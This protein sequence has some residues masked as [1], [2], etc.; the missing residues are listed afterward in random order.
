MKLGNLRRRP[1]SS[2]AEHGYF[3]IVIMIMVALLAI[4]SLSRVQNLTTELKR[5]REE[6]LVHRGAQ[7]AR[8]VQKFYR[9]FK[10]YPARI[11]QLENTNHM[12]F[13]RQRYKDP[14]TG[15]DFRLV[16][17]SELAFGPGQSNSGL[18]GNPA[19]NSTSRPASGGLN[20]P[21]A[22][23]FLGAA[24]LNGN[25]GAT[26]SATSSNAGK[27][28]MTSGENASNSTDNSGQNT[29]SSQN[30]SGSSLDTNS[31]S[32]SDKN[33]GS[34][35]PTFGGGPFIG[36]AS[37]SN[38]VSLKEFDKKNH[39]KDWLFVYLPIM[40]RGGAN[41]SAA[42][43]KGPFLRSQLT[44]GL[45]GGG[46]GAVGGNVIGN[47]SPSVFGNGSPSSASPFGSTTT[48]GANNPPTSPTR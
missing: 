38:R 30:N 10:Q 5:D 15:G 13:L 12:R 4:A 8:A 28:S 44:G 47:G 22:T 41:G 21:L 23:G 6:E 11:E 24:G 14:I 3:L 32:S 20:G 7:Y 18:F 36:V 34:S 19:A 27:N 1:S 46:A 48:G 26:N 25:P 33:F 43:I 17:E 40:D 45:F 16:R 31:G 2:N 35:G 37:T 42:L 29:S 9:K 39:Y